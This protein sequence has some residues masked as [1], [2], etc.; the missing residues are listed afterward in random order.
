V[1]DQGLI[2]YGPDFEGL[3]IP[4]GQPPEVHLCPAGTTL[5]F[6]A[7]TFELPDNL[8]VDYLADFGT[9]IVTADLDTTGVVAYH[10][11]CV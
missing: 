2:I 4:G 8:H 10:L 6:S 9:V 1:T 11:V 3:P 7:S 5:D